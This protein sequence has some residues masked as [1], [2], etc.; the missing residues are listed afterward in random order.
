MIRQN[1]IDRLRITSLCKAF[2]ESEMIKAY[3][4][5][6]DNAPVGLAIVYI[7]LAEK[8]TSK[9]INKNN[10]LFKLV[11][12]NDMYIEIKIG[13]PINTVTV[14]IKNNTLCYD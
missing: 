5:G 8:L 11:S 14:S 12:E 6:Y 3:N 13:K 7:Q 9:V 4:L 1:E 10:T 2:A